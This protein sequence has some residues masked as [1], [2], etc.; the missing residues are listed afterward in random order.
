MLKYR[1]RQK[2]SK[3]EI[4]MN[5]VETTFDPLSDRTTFKYEL[6]PGVT[7]EASSIAELVKKIK[8]HFYESE[9]DHGQGD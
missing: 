6:T 7:V 2:M 9:V 8:Q 1:R 4:S 5:E 3:D